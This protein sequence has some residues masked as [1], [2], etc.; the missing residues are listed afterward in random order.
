MNL[1]PMSDGTITGN[2]VCTWCCQ[3][4][5][6]GMN[7]AKLF[8]R[9]GLLKNYALPQHKSELICVI[10]DGWDV[11]YGTKNPEHIYRYGQAYP[12]PERFPS[13]AGMEPPHAL[14]WLADAVRAEGFGGVGLWIPMQTVRENHDL[15]TLEE[16]IAHWIPRAKWSEQAGISYWK[17]DWGEHFWNNADARIALTKLL[18]E[19][20]PHVMV[21][22]AY[23]PGRC[24][25]RE[26]AQITQREKEARDL[27][28]RRVLQYS[29]Y[30]R[31]YDCGGFT[32]IPTT[33]ARLSTLMEQAAYLQQD[34]VLHPRH[35]VNVEDDPYIA[36]ALGCTMG[37]MSFGKDAPGSRY[38]SLTATSRALYWQRI[39]PPF[40]LSPTGNYIDSEWIAN[41]F[42][43]TVQSAPGRLSRNWPLAEVSLQVGQYQPWVLTSVHPKSGALSCYATPRTVTD[44]ENCWSYADITLQVPQMETPIGIFGDSYLSLTLHFPQ[45][46]GNRRIY[47]QDLAAPQAIDVTEQVRIDQNQVILNKEQIPAFGKTICPE[48]DTSASGFLLRL[49]RSEDM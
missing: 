30:F 34:P 10:D 44:W 45:N 29:D 22:H 38:A 6:E 36:A 41:D 48:G 2:Y 20:A 16:Y 49:L 42:D 27:H 8:G 15:F 47:V 26:P 18:R 40:S 37:D 28:I 21:E 46:I 3:G 31:T 23:I 7:E 12:D 35:M 4:G 39:A 9:G 43:K 19:H 33:L 25:D 11:P 14:R 5:A 24:V 17:V 1:I 13:T 32:R